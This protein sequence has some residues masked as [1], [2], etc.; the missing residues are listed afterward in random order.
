MQQDPTRSLAILASALALSMGTLHAKP[1]I[2]IQQPGIALTAEAWNDIQIQASTDGR[3]QTLLT[4]TG[5]HLLWRPRLN[6]TRGVVQQITTAAGQPGVEVT[7]QTSGKEGAPS[8]QVVG[9]FVLHPRTVAV[10]YEISGVPVEPKPKL[11]GCMFG[12]TFA[13]GTKRVETAKLGRWQRPA[14]GGIPYEVKDGKLVRY[15]VGNQS[16]WLAFG[17]GNGVNLSWKGST[18]HHTGIRKVGEGRYEAAFAVVV[19]P[20]TYPAPMVAAQ[21]LHRPFALSLSTPKLNNCW[22]EPGKSLVLDAMLVNTSTEIRTL[23]VTH[24]VRGFDGAIVS[25]D[26]QAVAL[27]PGQRHDRRVSFRPTRDRGIYFAEVSA[28]DPATGQEEFART[29][30]TFLPPHEFRSTPADSI[31]GLAAY[32]PIPTEEDAQKLMDRMGVRWLRTGKTQL[33][34]AGRIA[35]HHSNIRW[36]KEWADAERDEWIKK[37]LTKCVENGNPYWEF[38]NEINMSTAGIAMEGHGIGKALLADTYVA[39]LRAIR[40]VQQETGMTQVKLLSFGIAG[41][42]EVFVRKIHELGAW[43]LL[44]GLAL[45]PGRGNFTPDYPVTNPYQSWEQ[46]PGDNFWNYYGAVRT[47]QSL[48]REQGSIPLW[49]TEIYT[50]TVPNS[51]WEDTPRN[52]AEN[53]VLTYALAKAEGVK[54]AMYYQL[55]DSVW[56][57][58]L[59]VNPKDREYFFGLVQRDLS[60]KPPLLAYCAIAEALDQASFTGWVKF[61]NAATRG[62]LFATPRGPLAILWNRADGYVL[63]K[64]AKPFAT[65]EPW[66]D[67]WQ[68]K[69]PTPLPASGETVT[70][71]NCIGQR[72]SVPAR[73]GSVTLTLDG[74]PTM[75]YGLDPQKLT[76]AAGKTGF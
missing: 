31:F 41:M 55:F 27:K 8:P 71:I 76:N 24:C 51:F 63:T 18:Q 56:Y 5:F 45:H 64:E 39:W 38:A 49:L 3:N 17:T 68:T 44:A 9:R 46:K 20:E 60:F 32:W 43:N 72:T 12:R 34:H 11:G 61:P 36:G 42:D 19:A 1:V 25:E 7:Y 65:P 47:A 23:A 48:I 6:T 29:N 59:G 57:D 52:A 35:N 14:H 10:H 73:D 22:T 67:T 2:S 66:V 28:T 30:L 62:L 21:W 16:F 74:A 69:T 33:Q 53:V 15:R 58:K 4:F 37:E 54:C 26:T 75:V 13:P 50:P 40:R 70:V